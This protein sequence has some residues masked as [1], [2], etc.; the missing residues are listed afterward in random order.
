M[1]INQELTREF[2]Q[3]HGIHFDGAFWVN[4]KCPFRLT[5]TDVPNNWLVTI[6]ELPVGVQQPEPI[7]DYKGLMYLYLAVL[8]GYIGK[9]QQGKN[10][11]SENAKVQ[12]FIE[13]MNGFFSFDKNLS[14]SLNITQMGVQVLPN[15]EYTHTIMSGNESS[16]IALDHD[17]NTIIEFS[18]APECVSYDY[19][20][21]L[22]KKIKP[23]LEDYRI[24]LRS[25]LKI[26]DDGSKDLFF[27]AGL[28]FK[29]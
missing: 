27:G 20:F 26:N 11:L 21:G 12:N 1:K 25:I 5:A 15:N 18:I 19:V 16:F 22:I 23:E 9:S 29:K 2:L 24:N 3:S 17:A 10:F 7:R 13:L 6:P 28:K 4:D 8:P 14:F